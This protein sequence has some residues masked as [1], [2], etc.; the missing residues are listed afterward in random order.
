MMLASKDRCGLL[1]FIFIGS[2]FYNQGQLKLQKHR[3][4]LSSGN[5]KKIQ[6]TREFKKSKLQE[7]MQNACTLFME[8]ADVK[9]LWNQLSV[10]LLTSSI[11][12]AEL[13]PCLLLTV[14]QM[15]F[16]A[17]FLMSHIHFVGVNTGR[18]MKQ[19]DHAFAS[20]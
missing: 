15:H 5:T 16:L 10:E 9:R 13:F 8:A 18:A 7:F 2:H 1:V 20:L 6:Q 11:S 12:I 19:D 14:T 4:N 3:Y 17:L